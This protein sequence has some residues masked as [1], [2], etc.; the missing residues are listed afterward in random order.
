MTTGGGLI[1]GVAGF[2]ALEAG[3]RSL[4]AL[5]VG[6]LLIDFGGRL[7]Q[8]A[9]QGR[10]YELRDGI[11]GRL[12]TAYMGT[13]LIA[14]VLGSAIGVAVFATGGWHASSAVGGGLYAA[15]LLVWLFERRIDPR[16]RHQQLASG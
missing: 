13:R 8:V 9:S 14:G 2:L 5:I 16:R 10:I 15:A 1:A 12:T 11:R 7:I 3:N 4:S 6:V